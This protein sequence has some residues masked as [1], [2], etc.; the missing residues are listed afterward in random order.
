MAPLFACA[1]KVRTA[2]WEF[3]E[4]AANHNPHIAAF[5]ATVELLHLIAENAR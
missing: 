2:G 3:Y 5:N 4:L 1:Q